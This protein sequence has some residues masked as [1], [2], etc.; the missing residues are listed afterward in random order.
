MKPQPGLKRADSHTSLHEE[1][2]DEQKLWINTVSKEVADSIGEKEKKRQEVISE[3]MYTERD[4]VK[5][6]EY[7]RD[8]WIKPLRN[9]ATSPVPEQ[10]RDKFIKAVFSNISEVWQVN[11]KLAESL[12]KRQAQNPV[13]QTVGDIFLTYVP[14]FSPFI[15][16][17]ASQL[18][19]KYEFENEKRNNPAF[20][21]FVDTT[22]RLKESR[23][24]ELNGYLT[25]PTTR[26]ARYPLLLEGVLKYTADDSS[27]KQDIPKAIELV[28]SFLHKVN[29]ESGKAENHFNLM[30]LSKELRFRPG[31]YV[32]LKLTE[33]NRQLIFKSN[34]K[35]NA[36]D[37]NSD[38]QAYLFD[39][40][41]LIVRIKTVNK[42]EELKV[43]RKPIPLEL[44]V[45]D[46]TSQLF[47]QTG[48]TKRPSSS[49]M[50][51]RTT[52][53]TSQMTKDSTKAQSYPLTFRH[54]GKGGYDQVL[55]CTTQIQQEK[56]IQ[57][58]YEQQKALRERSAIFTKTI[59]NQAF[60]GSLNRV[61]CCVPIGRQ[62]QL[63]IKFLT[64]LFPQMV[65]ENW[66]LVPRRACT[67]AT[68]SLALHRSLIGSSSSR[69]LLRSMSSRPIRS[70]LFSQTR[71]FTRTQW[72]HSSQTTAKEASPVAEGRFA[73]QT[74]SRLVY[75]RANS[76]SVPS[77]LALCRRQSRCMSPWTPWRRKR[78]NRAWPRCWLAARTC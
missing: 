28:R 78:R 61:N 34:L 22:E 9:P 58:V 51:T 23:K 37:T 7:M 17:G 27:D 56:F 26:L 45:I 35:K 43:Y 77:K 30:Q 76:S 59:V 10:R 18:F 67:Y 60:F 53:M 25:K 73:T 3:L 63:Y 21:R 54:L 6:L 42:K 8:F 57:Y 46:E 64:N 19:G 49:M 32:D 33:D 66:C 70:S 4:F 14:H 69:L 38:L 65:A 36:T 75:A 68:A 74:S 52:T 12:T 39:H 48:V 50:T 16:Y 41:V 44:L 11:M 24:L 2:G 31:E 55:Y 15:T 29:A 62:L 5:D 71:L 13:V 1:P 20:Q 47:P 40:A 72:K